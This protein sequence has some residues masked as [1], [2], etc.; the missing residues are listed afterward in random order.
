MR[1]R[2]CVH[3]CA[4]V[5]LFVCVC[6]ACACVRVC[7]CMSH[8]LNLHRKVGHNFHTWIPCAEC[9]NGGGGGRAAMHAVLACTCSS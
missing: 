8:T 3:V 7:V 5:H 4:C 9:G 6:A 1:V 2:A